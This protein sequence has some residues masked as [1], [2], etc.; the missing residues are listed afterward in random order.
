MQVAV[1][2]HDNEAPSGNALIFQTAFNQLLKRSH[3]RMD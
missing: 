2:V 3:K 1:N